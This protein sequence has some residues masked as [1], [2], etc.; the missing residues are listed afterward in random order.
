M[1]LLVTGGL[2]Y[3]GGFTARALAAA[4]HEVTLFDNL[5]TGR[6]GP[7]HKLPLVVGDC[8]DVSTLTGILSHGRIEAV[9][10]FAGLSEVGASA[11]D[12]AAYYAQNVGGSLGV[13]EAL[14]A[15]GVPHL[16][17]SSSAAVYGNPETQPIPE[18]AP[19]APGN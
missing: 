8:R 16:V 18:D 3:V 11:F 4:G 7:S 15:A 13:L 9:L 19:H 1:R 5:S 14:R 10:H 6:R 12:P 2:G 17:F